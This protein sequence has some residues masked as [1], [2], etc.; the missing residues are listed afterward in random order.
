MLKYIIF[1]AFVLIVTAIISKSSATAKIPKLDE[2]QQLVVVLAD[3]WDAVRARMLLFEKKGDTWI[4]VNSAYDAVV[5]SKGLAWAD[6][7]Q[8]TAGETLVKR[9][10]DRKAPAGIFRLIKSMGYDAVPPA[11]VT[12]SYEPIQEG[13]HCVDDRASK[14]YNKIV[15]EKDMSAPARELWKSSEIMKRK[16]I[17]YKW[18]VVV[19]YNTHNPRPGAGSC[20]FIHVMRSKDRGTA[21]CTAI[22][23]KD[24][25]TLLKWIKPEANPLL[26]QLPK[27]EYEKYGK[28]W[29]LPAP[30]LISTH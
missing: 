22:A 28:E 9:E 20:I 13:L 11:G 2:T 17:L 24:I 16:D 3:S 7:Q 19:D 21:G 18:L 5:G 12:F 4:K 26:V 29:K 14:Y 10:G 15:N 23:E 1:A 8:P 25:I 6:G 27:P 30:E